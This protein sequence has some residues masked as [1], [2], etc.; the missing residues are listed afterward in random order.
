MANNLFANVDLTDLFG[1][2]VELLKGLLY[3]KDKKHA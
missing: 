3:R 2:V 1:R